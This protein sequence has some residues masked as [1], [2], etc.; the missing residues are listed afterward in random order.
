MAN[1]MKDTAVTGTHVGLGLRR[2][3]AV[4]CGRSSA[5]GV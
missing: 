3:A 4:V 2:T 5:G 1:T